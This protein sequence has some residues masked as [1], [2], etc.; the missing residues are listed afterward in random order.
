MDSELATK[1]S[2]KNGRKSYLAIAW[3]L[4]VATIIDTRGAREEPLSDGLWNVQP[5]SLSPDWAVLCN[6]IR[7]REEVRVRKKCR[8]FMLIVEGIGI[9]YRPF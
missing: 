9:T 3:E 8:S 7:Q 5:E 2:R 4:K 6:M 1:V